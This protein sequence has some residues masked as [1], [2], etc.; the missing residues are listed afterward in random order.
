[1][2]LQPTQR[3]H[4]LPDM[5][6]GHASSSPRVAMHAAI[7]R[8][9]R[10]AKRLLCIFRLS[11]VHQ[12][13]ADMYLSS[14]S[15]Q[16]ADVATL[17][18][19]TSSLHYAELDESPSALK[20]VVPSSIA[21]VP[22]LLPL[23]SH[24]T[25]QLLAGPEDGRLFVLGGR[26]CLI[27]NDVLPEET[28]AR[29]ISG[30]AQAGQGS[31]NSASA[32]RLAARWR[33]RRGLYLSCLS[34]SGAADVLSGDGDTKADHWDDASSSLEPSTPILLRPSASLLHA[35]GSVSDVEK[36]CNG[37]L[38][39]A[40]WPAKS[41][42]E[43][44]LPSA[45]HDQ[46][47]PSIL[48][49]SA[50]V[51]FV[52]NGSLHLSYSLD[53]H[54]VLRVSPSALAKA[55]AR[56]SAAA[57]A[58]GRDESS[59]RLEVI[60]ELVYASRFAEQGDGGSDDVAEAKAGAKAAAK[61]ARP[62]MRGGTPAVRIGGRYL[63]FMHMVWKRDGRSLYAVAG[64]TFSGSPPFAIEAMTRPFSLSGH[65]TPYPVGL[66]ASGRH[67]L[68]SYGVQDREWHVA[69]LDKAALLA[70]LVPVRTEDTTP[71][72]VPSETSHGGAHV[73]AGDDQMLAGLPRQL[74]FFRGAPVAVRNAVVE[75][76]RA[77][78]REVEI[79]K[80]P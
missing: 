68:L 13:P 10:K 44:C 60:A 38:E 58:G 22:R 42:S 45:L 1:M 2:P 71:A 77:S 18:A 28:T 48:A 41:K 64:Y 75:S 34:P 70:A 79:E 25:S 16:A 80:P 55:E 61:A 32:A 62:A 11:D 67:L 4:R 5:V 19:L 12:P 53:P 24:P 63:A 59:A 26:P 65:A 54:Y 73:Q 31:A 43:P 17:R 14:D 36:N 7:L 78:Q 40:P 9:P 39:S 33:M 27:Y 50:G 66:V 8:W 3:H 56:A 74:H 6:R 30:T 76:L 15:S 21:A 52:H 69:R 37:S 20:V 47:T 49:S 23:P 72:V 46:R 35:V 29:T 51:P 57:E